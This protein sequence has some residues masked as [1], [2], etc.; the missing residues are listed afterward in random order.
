MFLLVR[1]FKILYVYISINYNVRWFHFHWKYSEDKKRSILTVRAY[2]VFP[3]HIRLHVRYFFITSILYVYVYN[4]WC[5][6]T[7]RWKLT[8]LCAIFW[9]WENPAVFRASKSLATIDVDKS[10]RKN[11]KTK[12][13]PIEKPFRPLFALRVVEMK[14][15]RKP[16]EFPSFETIGS[17]SGDGGVHDRPC[18]ARRAAGAVRSRAE[19]ASRSFTRY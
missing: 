2:I 8:V 9:V 7:G 16:F 11:K 12:G 17:G 19:G 4:F 5:S 15:N 14:F 3:V 10:K 13:F 6:V 18:R 1:V